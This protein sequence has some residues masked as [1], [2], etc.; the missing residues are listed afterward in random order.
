MQL[1]LGGLGPAPWL[2]TATCA[3]G[4][5][6]FAGDEAQHCAEMLLLGAFTA[7]T[8]LRVDHWLSM[9]VPWLQGAVL[10]GHLAN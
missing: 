9:A 2:C 5:G 7:V 4:D 6:F 1:L 3:F 8:E 10:I